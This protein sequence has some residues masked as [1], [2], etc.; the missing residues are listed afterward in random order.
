MCADCFGLDYVRQYIV[1][2]FGHLARA[3]H[4]TG[5]HAGTRLFLARPLQGYILIPLLVYLCM[6]GGGC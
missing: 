4:C 5:F 3:K 1:A 6:C 2:F